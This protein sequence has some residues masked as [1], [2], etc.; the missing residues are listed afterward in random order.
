MF[1]RNIPIFGTNHYI[2]CVVSP[3]DIFSSP[4]GDVFTTVVDE[5]KL[6]IAQYAKP[7]FC[8]YHGYRLIGRQG[9]IDR[10]PLRQ[11]TKVIFCFL[12]R[13]QDLL[14]RTTPFL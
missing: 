11:A 6:V 13:P 8:Q 14:D 2:A 1:S 7:V 4:E 10:F 3:H 9:D 12:P 5:S